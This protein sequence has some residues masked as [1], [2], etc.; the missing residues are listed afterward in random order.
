V[1]YRQPLGDPLL[2]WGEVT[3]VAFGPNSKML[4]SANRFGT[5][6]IWDIDPNSWAARL[7]RVANR[8]LSISEWRHF[9][10]ATVP[11]RRTCPDLPPGVGA[12]AK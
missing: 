3:S 10:G 2:G 4:A 12:P 5:V 6:W 7:C 9:I 11:Y 8:N 1:G